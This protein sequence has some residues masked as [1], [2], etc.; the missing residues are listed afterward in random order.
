M[1]EHLC[2]L[3]L[4]AK[5]SQIRELPGQ[6][7]GRVFMITEALQPQP[8]KSMGY[9]VEHMG[10]R[11]VKIHGW[12]ALGGGV[13]ACDEPLAERPSRDPD[14]GISK[15]EE[16][17][18]FFYTRPEGRPAKVAHFTQRPKD[19]KLTAAKSI[20]DMGPYATGAY[21]I[22]EMAAAC[23][24]LFRVLPQERGETISMVTVGDMLDGMIGS[25]YPDALEGVMYRGGREGASDFERF[26]SRSLK[27]A[28]AESVRAI[29]AAH[30]VDLRRLGSTG[31]FW[32]GCD[33]RELTSQ[34]IDVLQAVEGALNRLVFID[35]YLGEESSPLVGSISEQECER[36]AIQSL[37]FFAEGSI[38]AIRASDR[39]NDFARLLG[40]DAARGGE[41]D[42]RTRFA[43]AAEGLR[44]PFSFEYLFD[45]DAA[46]G[47]FSVDAT[48]PVADAFPVSE[49]EQRNDARTAYTLRLGMALAAIAFGSSVGIVRVVITMHERSLDG[50]AVCSFELS[51]QLFTMETVPC[52]RTGAILDP[53]LSIE[54][55]VELLSPRTLR[56]EVAADR[57]L[58]PVEPIDACLPE[59][60]DQMAD[61]VRSLPAD[62][63]E[64][65]RA[66]TVA[67]LDIFD[68]G[69]DPLRDRYRELCDRIQEQAGHG[70]MGGASVTA[71]VCDII[72]AYDAA[73]MLQ[74]DSGRPLYCSNM[75]ARIAV[76]LFDEGLET[77]YRKI[78]DTAY[79]ARSLLC[80]LYRDQGNVEDAIRLGEELVAMAPTSFASY[81]TLALSYREAERDAD[82]ARVIVDGMRVAVDPNDIACGYYRLGFLFWQGGDPALGLACYTMVARDSFFYGETQSE[83]RELMQE[84]HLGRQPERDE[85]IALL[86]AEGVPVAPIAQLRDRA[87]MAAIRL[88]DAGLFNAAISLVHFLATFD[89]APNSFDVLA[90]VRR[91]LMR[92]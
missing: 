6:E 30:D 62:L 29:A 57:S 72:A 60:A 53:A 71:E 88:V 85:A 14:A 86:R 92:R 68:D 32:T 9:I 70:E 8:E 3:P 10:S 40:T 7:R 11:K 90:S 45:C 39:K 81:H 84:A 67:E 66:R 80:R 74:E 44:A 58:L 77:R 91:S 89:V 16:G 54:E 78:P 63:V 31:L 50:E 56:L 83:M 34:Q 41:W 51:R 55:L 13:Y 22:D 26:A 4:F 59:R 17:D 42:V 5:T 24:I 20:V 28:G 37:S 38:K 69:D 47:V 43:S 75:V 52:I 19:F 27:E 36:A 73:E 64:P 65:L 1:S 33:K 21:D 87:A 46:A 76:G 35:H 79:D 61:D 25:S 15:D 48:V 2:K 12:L 18:I 82:A 49:Q 23:F